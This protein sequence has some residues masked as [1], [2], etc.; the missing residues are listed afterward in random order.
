MAG[1]ESGLPEVFAAIPSYKKIKTENVPK[2]KAR[3]HILIT[4]ANEEF[5]TAVQ[6]IADDTQDESTLL[7]V[8]TDPCANLALR[9]E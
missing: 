3:Y 9:I 7:R 1:P 5:Q 4:R 2:H 6:A 8:L